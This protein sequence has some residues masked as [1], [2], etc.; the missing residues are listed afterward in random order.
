ME[1][2]ELFWANCLVS[3]KEKEESI[4]ARIDLYPEVC[5]TQ[6]GTEAQRKQ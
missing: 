6:L 5:P 2:C 3:K 4:H 1:L